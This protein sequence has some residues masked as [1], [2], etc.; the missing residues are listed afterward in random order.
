MLRGSV[1]GMTRGGV[2]KG[3]AI[4]RVMTSAAWV[5][6]WDDQSGVSEG[7]GDGQDNDK[8]VSVDRPN[9]SVGLGELP[10][11]IAKP[12]RKH[13]IYKCHASGW[14][15]SPRGRT[16]TLNGSHINQMKSWVSLLA[17]VTSKY[18]GV[19]QANIPARRALV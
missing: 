6:E 3:V 5:S 10:L 1:N 17:P 16:E 9:V 14:P 11:H 2:V 13:C 7:S 8:Y 15:P 4:V 18:K 19:G 12:N